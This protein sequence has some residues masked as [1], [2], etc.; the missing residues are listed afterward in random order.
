MSDTPTDTH[1]TPELVTE[2]VRARQAHCKEHPNCHG[3]EYW[4]MHNLAE[5][6]VAFSIDYNRQKKSSNHETT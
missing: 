3:C 2:I 4:Q 5:C 6:L 1:V